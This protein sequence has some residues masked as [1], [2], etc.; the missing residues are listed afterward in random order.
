MLAE[1][2]TTR[3]AGAVRRGVAAGRVLRAAAARAR[4]CTVLPRW[5]MGLFLRRWS[6]AAKLY[7]M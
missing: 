7:N 4:R 2:I 3:S 6:E 1:T 5:G